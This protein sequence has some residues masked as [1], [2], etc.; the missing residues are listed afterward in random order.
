MAGHHAP[1]HVPHELCL[2]L[3]HDVLR[4]VQAGDH[5][6]ERTHQRCK[7]NAGDRQQE[8]AEG[9]LVEIRRT[10]VAVANC[11]HGHRREVDRPDV[12][13]LLRSVRDLRHDPVGRDI[14]A[15]TDGIPSAAG[16]VDQRGQEEHQADQVGVEDKQRISLDVGLDALHDSLHLGQAEETSEAQDSEDADEAERP[17]ASGGSA[18]VFLRLGDPVPGDG[19]EDIEREPALHVFLGEHRRSDHQTVLVRVGSDE[20]RH[21]VAQEV[22]RDD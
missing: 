8:E 10:D 18:S 11:G 22:R 20:G 17:R 5:I 15:R 16:P 9:D 19:G 21:D 4:L 12:G 7:D 13:L 2:L 1:V 6:R 3:G 14:L